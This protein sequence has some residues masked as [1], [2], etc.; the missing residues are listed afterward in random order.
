MGLTAVDRKRMHYFYI[1]EQ[2]ELSVLHLLLEVRPIPLSEDD[3]V[4]VAAA[5]RQCLEQACWGDA[6]AVN[7][8]LSLLDRTHSSE[9]VHALLKLCQEN[10]SVA[11]EQTLLQLKR[12]V[13]A[14][15][16]V[17]CSQN[18]NS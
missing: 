17:D 1:G 9:S 8:C 6:S 15:L 4:I 13:I 14:E 16:Q 2:R 10:D 5:C 12:Q 3:H 18:C 11:V 7:L